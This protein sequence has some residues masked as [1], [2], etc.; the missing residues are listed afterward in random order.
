M[1]LVVSAAERVGFEP[2]V[3]CATHALQACLI[4]HSSTSP[5]P[6]HTMI[7]YRSHNM[8]VTSWATDT[9]SVAASR[10]MEMGVL[11]SGWPL[12]LKYV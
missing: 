1:R 11:N 2:T 5:A 6:A 3:A 10:V 7:A 9:H 4:D 8:V 12:E